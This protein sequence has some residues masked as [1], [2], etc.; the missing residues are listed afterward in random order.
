MRPLLIAHF[1]IHVCFSP[2]QAALSNQSHNDTNIQVVPCFFPMAVQRDIPQSSFTRTPEKL[3]SLS[4]FV[5]SVAVLIITMWV[6]YIHK[7][8]E[9]F[10]CLKVKVSMNLWVLTT[11]PLA[12]T[13]RIFPWA[14]LWHCWT[15]NLGNPLRGRAAEDESWRCLNWAL[16]KLVWITP[17]KTNMIMEHHHC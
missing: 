3:Q 6:F 2:T 17:L 9:S 15:I 4:I 13:W 14:S 12:A 7:C 8:H 5:N 1:K 10:L 11:F 16:Q